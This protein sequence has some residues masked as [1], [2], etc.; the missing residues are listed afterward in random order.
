MAA[1]R[2]RDRTTVQTV[3]LVYGVVFLLVGIVGLLMPSSTAARLML[4]RVRVRV[5][6]TIFRSTRFRASR[7]ETRSGVAAAAMPRSAG[8][9][10]RPRVRMTARSM[11]FSSSRMFPGHW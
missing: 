10:R 7:S 1:D 9:T 3:A 2:D 4:P 11:A 6:T 5:S 8:S